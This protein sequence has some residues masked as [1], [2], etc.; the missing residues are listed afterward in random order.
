MT[1]YVSQKIKYMIHKI[2]D[3]RVLYI[4]KV[5]DYRV[6][7]IHKVQDYRVLDNN[8]V[9][10]VIL[11]ICRNTSITASFHKESIRLAYTRHVLLM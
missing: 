3:N 7:F 5:Q 10:P 1:T 11:L 9:R 4:H 6:L 8:N 2:Q